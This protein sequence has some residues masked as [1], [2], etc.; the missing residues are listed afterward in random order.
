MAELFDAPMAVGASTASLES[1][2]IFG[3]TALQAKDKNRWKTKIS[4]ELQHIYTQVEY[5][6]QLSLKTARQLAVLR[7][8][9]LHHWML[10]NSMPWVAKMEEE[11]QLYEKNMAALQGQD[12]KKREMPPNQMKIFE[13]MLQS[14]Q[15]AAV[16]MPVETGPIVT[17]KITELVAYIK[18]EGLKKVGEQELKHL[19]LTPAYKRENIKMEVPIV[20]GTKVFTC[21]MEIIVPALLASQGRKQEGTE[22]RG[23]LERKCQ[24]WLDEL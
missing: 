22:P 16:H 1:T 18:Q 9:A 23:D 17:A 21:W 14:M 15:G 8:L 12:E 13:S 7:A 19:K 2:R 20:P 4:P 24:Q 3:S 5:L 11:R 6:T 10:K